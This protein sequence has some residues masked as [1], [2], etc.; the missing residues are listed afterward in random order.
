MLRSFPEVTQLAQQGGGIRIQVFRP[1]ATC[2]RWPRP[3]G[4][5]P[6]R[7]LLTAEGDGDCA[8]PG[9]GEEVGR[10]PPKTSSPFCVQKSAP[11]RQ[12]ARGGPPPTQ[13]SSP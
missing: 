12:R 2:P 5:E 13:R 6:P 4:R 3:E 10:D 8:C 1:Q 11:S 7:V 9:G